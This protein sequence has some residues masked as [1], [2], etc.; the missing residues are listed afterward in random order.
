[1]TGAEIAI[2]SLFAAGTGLQAYSQY[3]Q[4]KT[5]SQQAKAQAAWHAY[6]A[7]IA[8]RNAEYVRQQMEIEER[9]GR[10]LAEFEVLKYQRQT[11]QV[12]ARLRALRGASGVTMEGSPLLAAEDTASQLALEGSNRLAG[13]EMETLRRKEQRQKEIYAYRSR[14]ILDTYKSSAANYAAWNY[15][16]A[17]AFGAG[18][19]ILQ[20]AG[21]MAFA[22]YKMGMFTPNTMGEL[23]SAAD[24]ANEWL[25]GLEG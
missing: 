25:M 5:A 7:K 23:N 19:S 15:R 1:M 18:A 10:R 6:N 22:G 4:G 12:M 14:S 11:K 17:G 20:G 2:I 13:I 21:Q 3:Q 16:R 9:A 8:K 24:F